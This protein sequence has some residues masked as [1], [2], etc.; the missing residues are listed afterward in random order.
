MTL[1]QID[2]IEE[3]YPATVAQLSYAFKNSD[4]GIILGVAGFNEK[5]HVK[6]QKLK[7]KCNYIIFYRF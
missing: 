6:L 1:M 5:L 3:A 4:K 2:L 7:K